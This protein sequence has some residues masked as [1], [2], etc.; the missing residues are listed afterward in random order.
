M[1]TTQRLFLLLG[2]VLP[3]Y[4]SP[5]QIVSF[6]YTEN[7]DSVTVPVFPTGWSASG[8]I[9]SASSS[10]SAPNCVYA[11]GN[12]TTKTLTSPIF[13]L[14]GRKPQ[15][16]LFY[17][18]RSLTA[19]SYR[20]ELRAAVNDT[21]FSL[22]LAR[23]DTSTATSGYIQRSIDLSAAVLEN[24]LVQFRWILLAD[25]TNST[26]TLRLDDISLTLQTRSDVG[27]SSAVLSPALPTWKDSLT[28]RVSIKN[29]AETVPPFAVHLYKDDNGNRFP[30]PAEFFDT[31]QVSSL[32]AGDSSTICF[33]LPPQKRG[34][35]QFILVTQLPLD[36]NPSNDTLIVTTT[37]GAACG[38]ILINEFLYA[39]V[40]EENE[41][42]ELYNASH[43][44]INIKGW[45][46]SDLNITTKTR[47]SQTD[48]LL[49]PAGYFVLCKDMGFFELHPGIPAVQVSFA[50]LNNTTPDALVLYE[51]NNRVIDSLRYEPHWGGNNGK[52]LERIDTELPATLASNW[53]TS[54]SAVG[55]PGQGNSVARKNY[56]IA[57]TSVVLLPDDETCSLQLTISNIG[58]NALG[59]DTIFVFLDTNMNQR[60]EAEEVLGMFRIDQLLQPN[61]SLRF[62][63]QFENIP[64]GT[65]KLFVLLMADK[66]ERLSNNEKYITVQKP[67]PQSTVI[68]NEIS[69]APSEGACEWLELYNRDSSAVDLSGWY[70]ADKPTASGARNVFRLSQRNFI[71]HP[72]SF[73]VIAAESSFF[74]VYPSL[75]N[76]SHTVF[77]LN[78]PAGFSFNNDSDAITLYDHTGKMIDSIVYSATWVISKSIP[79]ERVDTELPALSKFQWK[80]SENPGGT[81]CS[82]NSVARR[83]YDIALGAVQ[84]SYM[85]G[86]CSLFVTIQNAGRSEISS[87]T[88][89]IFSVAHLSANDSL[90]TLL[91]EHSYAAS[92]QPL[93][94]VVV[95]VVLENLRVGKNVLT[96]IAG[97]AGDERETNNRTH[98]E[99]IVPAPRS[100]IVI[101]EIQPAPPEGECEWM[102]LYNRTSQPINLANWKFA[103]APTA[104]GN[105]NVFRLPDT[106]F[107][108]Q[109]FSFCVIAAES[110]F[111]QRY[112]SFPASV[113]LCILNRATGF[114]FN[115]DSDAIVLYDETG[116][117]ID[118][119][120]YCA[121]WGNQKY[122]PL[123]RV[124]TERP[125]LTSTNWK[126]STMPGGTPGGTN[127]VE[128]KQYDLAITRLSTAVDT[129]RNMK[130]EI[131]IQNLGRAEAFLQRLVSYYNT[132][133][134]IAGK[135][136]QVLATW[137]FLESIA[138][139]DSL[140]LSLSLPKLE[141]G[142][143]VLIV[144]L[145]DSLDERVTN[146]R[147][148]VTVLQS[149]PRRC[150][151]VNEIMFDPFAGESEWFEVYNP[152]EF[153]VNLQEWKFTDAPTA[154]GN[155]NTYGI[156]DSSFLLL[157]GRYCCIAADS[158]ILARFEYLSSSSL[159]ILNQKSF[160]FGNDSDAVVLYDHT[161]NLIDSVR[162]FSHWHHPSLSATKGRSLERLRSDLDSNLPSN[163]STCTLSSGG[164][165]AQRNSIAPDTSSSTET[166]SCFP[167]PFSPDGD[168]HEDFCSLSYKVSSPAVFVTV[169]IF[170]IRGRLVRTLADNEYRSGS[171][172]LLWDGYDSSRRRARI[173]M[174]IV[175]F[176]ASDPLRHI[177]VTAKK[178]VVVATK[179]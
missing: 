43:D 178:I 152:S 71:L 135:E 10:H 170:D 89:H 47:I 112:P 1:G 32:P 136:Q 33:L 175:L 117:I 56:D 138:P 126:S 106:N 24:A 122:A 30:E 34:N 26:G 140:S 127:T 146:N 75:R 6:P 29:L 58:R 64:S 167:N 3:L 95:P 20:L 157:P 25:G 90:T 81:P 179:L 155:K 55:T 99:V 141:P 97:L 91:F 28:L 42:I 19:L 84:S 45:K 154:S 119:V 21:N 129:N 115:N 74:D 101:T 174:Y 18:R 107:F 123:E 128:Q 100:S 113:P 93:D 116:C 49:P 133:K 38:D 82:A 77:I 166:F 151:L 158:S 61:D 96:I 163:W 48:V 70:F 173:G 98:L 87:F 114:S 15:A 83:K 102:E 36:E 80:N 92:L 145:Q 76:S 165:P 147:A 108:L 148:E 54:D 130:L 134:N 37:I 143:I 162:Y 85:E 63:V 16:L 109:P 14:R 73:A 86:V 69:V 27:I 105:R 60:G 176:E 103:D 104:S 46:V 22:L 13:D 121:Q 59:I 94:S 7:F 68:I 124:D 67:F 8:F 159:L 40:G 65:H 171:D 4:F 149:Y 9:L 118:S 153:P 39:P 125:A 44:T 52:S 142:K 88:L 150:L 169:R 111:L 177:T 72:R 144:E 12:T 17:D 139:G 35:A 131:L 23:F 120:V 5:A 78:S 161:G 110:V 50:A 132:Q 66:D 168:G 79:F 11:S 2:I 62:T 41:W 137:F 172:V 164:T 160:S 51:S 156:V 57:L 53:R 31:L